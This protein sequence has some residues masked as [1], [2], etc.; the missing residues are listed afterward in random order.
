[1]LAPPLTPSQVFTA[2]CQ[3]LLP[4]ATLD[5]LLDSWIPHPH[6]GTCSAHLG[7]YVTL[8]FSL[9]GNWNKKFGPGL[10]TWYVLFLP[11]RGIN[12]GAEESEKAV[13]IRSGLECRPRLSSVKMSYHYSNG[14]TPLMSLK[15][16]GKKAHNKERNVK[17]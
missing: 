8:T 7:T 15:L 3:F 1:M 5:I 16:F 12:L 11:V 4:T 17:V 10:H 9:L 6:P 13:R 14:C 2:T